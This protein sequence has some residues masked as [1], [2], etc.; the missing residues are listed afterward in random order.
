LFYII[1]I[2]IIIII[3]YILIILILTYEKSQGMGTMGQR[4]V[5]RNEET[6][7]V[8]TRRQE[9]RTWDELLGSGC[10]SVWG[11]EAYRGTKLV[12][13]GLR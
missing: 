10:R 6:G 2:Y 11:H 4:D 1:I 7:F 5:K 9:Q 3:L 8:G 13:T 12:G